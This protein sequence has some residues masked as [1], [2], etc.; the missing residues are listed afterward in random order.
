MDQDYRTATATVAMNRGIDLQRIDAKI[1]IEPDGDLRDF[2]RVVRRALL[3][4]VRYIEKRY[5]IKD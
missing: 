1:D 2:L 5:D 3:M 4:I